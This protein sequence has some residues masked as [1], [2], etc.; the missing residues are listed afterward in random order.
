M[1]LKQRVVASW[2]KL[3][4]YPKKYTIPG[5]V[6]LVFVLLYCVIFF[7]DKPVAFSYA[8]STC[9]RYLTLL[10]DMQKTT[11]NGYSAKPIHIWKIGNL[12]LAASSVC[13]TPTEPPHEGISNVMLSPGGG[14]LMRKTFA[15]TVKSPP[16]AQVAVLSKPVP[17]SRPLIL[18]LS[19]TDTIFTYHMKVADVEVSCSSKDKA[20]SCEVGKLGL[21][22]GKPYTIELIRQ[23]N[24]KNVAMVVKKDVMTLSATYV[25]DSS[26]KPDETVY[27]KPKVFDFV[28]DK[29]IAKATSTIIRVK[30]EIRTPVVST[31][32]IADN[33]LQLTV[34]DDLPRLATYEIAIDKVEAGDGSG[35]EAPYKLAFKTSGGP[36]VTGVNVGRTGVALGA[37]VVISFDQQLSETQDAS[38]FIVTSGGAAISGK[39]GNQIFISLSGVPQCGDFSIKLTNDLQ[40]NYEIAGSSAWNFA[41]RTICHTVGAIGYSSKGRPINAY[42]FGSGPTTVLY[43]GA[44][45]GNEV[46]TRS[47][48]Y[49]WVDEL[50]ANARS[51]PA[52]K[53]AVIVP[54]INPDGVASGS[55]TNGHNIDLNRNFA[56]SDWQ[57]DITDVNN[58]P[59]P[60]GGGSSPM[61]EPETQAIAALA[62]RL[63]P[64]LI[65]S[66][67]SQGGLLAA[68]QAGNSNALA[69]TYSQLSGYRNTTGQSS[70]TFEYSISGT[71]DDWYAEQ[72]GVA[73][74]LI[75]L[76]SHTNP[77]F[78]HNQ[79]AMW[80][81]L[82]N[83]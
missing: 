56:T 2:Q 24:G 7:I 49:S 10:P 67:H 75:E 5:G 69:D 59:F 6:A 48:L 83:S 78:S 63:R 13:F 80:A 50:E 46:S 72:L 60:G 81:M 38:K 19:D 37:T 71:A 39:K 28:F 43:T 66:Y 54:Q 21:L 22:Q 1:V 25:S 32:A 30:G 31:Q 74:V 52:G 23:F 40:S 35:L 18:P 20:I 36:R 76:G 70:T 41:S 14:L 15:L 61:S 17:L 68:N 26:V 42:Y 62:S 16:T 4:N 34:S 9:T 12:A 45:H 11:G 64:A 58:Q 57:T 8:G 29:P 55:R 65:L 47:L 27:A 53:S 3:R 44:I 51:I 73:S 77:Q 82:N 33:K 79:K